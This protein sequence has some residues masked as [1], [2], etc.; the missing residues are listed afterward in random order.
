MNKRIVV[1]FVL[2]GW[3]GVVLAADTEEK[4]PWDRSV[5][6]GYD[7]KSGNT[8]KSSFKLNL[9]VKWDVEK[10]RWTLDGTMN[11]GKTDDVKDD[12]KGKLLTEYRYKQTARFYENI[13]ASGEYDKMADLDYR[14][15]P[16]V[17][18]GY[19]IY[20]S[21]VQELSASLGPTYLME[22][23]SNGK[24]IDYWAAQFAFDYQGKIKQGTKY[25]T[26][27][28]ANLRIDNTENYLLNGEVGVE[29][30][31]G[32]GLGLRLVLSDEYN[33]IPAEDKK[34]NDVTL[35]SGLSF[36]F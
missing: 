11:Y 25:W 20:K 5:A 6:L 32:Y 18:A 9:G 34:R 21:D 19:T 17:G 16:G 33:N 27:G 13:F 8:D 28:S 3:F 4:N 23:Y 31:L 15:I 30:P 35:S 7:K 29:A 2:L 22:K 10:M 26:K 14:Y 36:S 12:D 1:L 24:K